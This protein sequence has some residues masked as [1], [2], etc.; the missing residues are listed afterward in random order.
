M[1]IFKSKK[2]K[3]VD[4]ILMTMSKEKFITKT[5]TLELFS[6][7]FQPDVNKVISVLNSSKNDEHINVSQNMF[8]LVKKKWSDVID[9]NSTIMKLVNGEEKRFVMMISEVKERISRERRKERPLLTN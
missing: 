9:T 2:E 6:D 5:K 3:T 4:E 8:N 1:N 7:H